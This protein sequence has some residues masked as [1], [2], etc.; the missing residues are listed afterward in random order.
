MSYVHLIYKLGSV[1]N[2]LKSFISKSFQQRYLT[3]PL[4]IKKS[5]VSKWKKY[6]NKINE[7]RDVFK[8]QPN[9]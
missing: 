4:L 8:T 5:L 6:Q 2:F 9:I 7:G 3:G 1:G